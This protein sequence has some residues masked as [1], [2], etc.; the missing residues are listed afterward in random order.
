MERSD[1]NYAEVITIIE[2][3][4]PEFQQASETWALSLH[5]D[6][7]TSMVAYCQMRTLSGPHMLERCQ[8]AWAEDRA[9]KLDFPDKM[10]V[11]QQADIVAARWTEADEGHLLHLWLRVPLQHG[12]NDLG[13]SA[14]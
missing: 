12:E 11:R 8:N 2:G 4:T 10:G 1:E 3:P 14:A 9:V 7:H 5:E 13:F 6:V